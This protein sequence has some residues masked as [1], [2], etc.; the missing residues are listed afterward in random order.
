[1]KHESTIYFCCYNSKT[2]LW[3][4]LSQLCAQTTVGYR[5]NQLNIYFLRDIEQTNRQFPHVS[6]VSFCPLSLIHFH[7]P[8]PMPSFSFICPSFCPLSHFLKKSIYPEKIS[9]QHFQANV[10]L[11]KVFF[12]FSCEVHTLGR[13]WILIAS[14]QIAAAQRNWV[15]C[16]REGSHL[17]PSPNAAN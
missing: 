5:K 14:P 13:F 17:W 2:C 1:M 9:N 12:F 3:E 11:S 16:I 8:F 4:G 6:F 7:L 10:G 15:N